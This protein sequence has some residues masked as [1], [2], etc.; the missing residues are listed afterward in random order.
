MYKRKKKLINP[1]LQLRLVAIFLFVAV[2]AVQIEAILAAL[3]LSQLAESLPNDGP[4]VLAEVDS[5]PETA[6]VVLENSAGS[7]FGLGTSADE[8]ADIAEETAVPND[9]KGQ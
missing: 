8:L 7:G 4:L 6:M 3:S 9:E 5:G 1:R 2:L